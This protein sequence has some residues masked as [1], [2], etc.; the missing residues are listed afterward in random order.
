MEGSVADFSPK[1]SYGSFH[2]FSLWRRCN[3]PK[4]WRLS[5]SSFSS[6]VRVSN[7]IYP[8]TWGC[9]VK[10]RWPNLT[11]R[12]NL[13]EK[14]NNFLFQVQSFVQD[15]F[16]EDDI[17]LGANRGTLVLKEVGSGENEETKKKRR[18]ETFRSCTFYRCEKNGDWS[19][20]CRVHQT[21]AQTAS[22]SKTNRAN[23]VFRVLPYKLHRPTIV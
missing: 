20:K 2:Y 8:A 12:S 11:L 4:R 5:L 13:G 14:Y 18:T 17:Y 6:P 1:V 16:N 21:A 7:K 10:S 22:P 19:R 23:V 9:A 15:R 3:T